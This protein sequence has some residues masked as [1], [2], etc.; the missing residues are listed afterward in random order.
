MDTIRA[1]ARQQA[2]RALWD[3]KPV[4]REVY[5][6]LYKRVAA[7][8]RPGLT[9]EVG[10]GSGNF[11]HYRPDALSFDI[12]PESWLDLVADAQF[13]PF[14]DATVANI[15]MLDVL[16][17]IQYPV[18][19]LREA[20]RV[21]SPRGRLIFVEP[22]ITPVSCAV[23]RLFHEEP[24]WM[25]VDPLTDGEIDPGKDPYVGN[26]AIPTLL[27]TRFAEERARAIPHLRPIRV[28]WLSLFAY[29][30]SGGFK[31]WSLLS[32][33]FARR[34]LSIED[35][36]EHRLGRVMGFRLFAVL[37]RTQGDPN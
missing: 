3:R 19:F 36:L 34:L 22:A 33:S 21:L 30:L 28:D 10:G 17:H 13:L 2:H 16:H 31:P 6:H 11:K 23:Y 26:Q 32:A 15:V 5:S 4:L 35:R 9:V 12:V 25:N 24:V 1:D 7:H 8:C 29:P 18:R 20:Q 14:G 27:M 37:E